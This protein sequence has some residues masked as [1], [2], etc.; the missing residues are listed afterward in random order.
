MTSQ[1]QK[2]ETEEKIEIFLSRN[3]AMY[4]SKTGFSV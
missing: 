3:L 4:V 2:I 1:K